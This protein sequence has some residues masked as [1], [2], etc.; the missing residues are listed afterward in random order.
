MKSTTLTVGSLMI[1]TLLIQS[2]AIIRGID[3]Y[4][5]VQDF[6]CL[7]KAGYDFAITRAWRSIGVFDQ[8]SLVNLK[9]AKST[10]MDKVD[11]YLFPCRGMSAADQVD[12]LIGNLTG[13]DYGTIWLDIETN[14]TQRCSW[15]NY[16][17]DENC[18][19]VG[20]L[21]EAVQANDKP[22]GIYASHYMWMQIFHDYNTCQQFKD[23]PLW[24]AHYDGKE[25]FSDFVSFGGW[26]T[27]NIKQHTGL[28][29][30]C[31]TVVDLNFY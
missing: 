7:K 31:D 17:G 26:T 2:Q 13:T 20:E 24:Y 19:Y 4:P 6:T 3:L 23:L 28:A 11:V 5:E 14:P 8:V 27:P 1:S 15:D 29:N 18:A 22:V 16:T 30:V 25:T 9:A 12:Q 10:G 21:V